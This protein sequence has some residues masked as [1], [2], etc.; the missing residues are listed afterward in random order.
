M[1]KIKKRR[2]QHHHLKANQQTSEHAN[3]RGDMR[4]NSKAEKQ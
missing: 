3:M 4:A 2:D 1:A